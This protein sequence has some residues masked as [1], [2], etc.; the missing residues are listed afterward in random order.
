[1]LAWSQ[2]FILAVVVPAWLW[3]IPFSNVSFVLM[4]LS[5]FTCWHEILP[6]PG[7]PSALHGPANVSQ[8]TAEQSP[9]RDMGKGFPLATEH[10][11]GAGRPVCF[12]TQMSKVR[13]GLISNKTRLAAVIHS[14]VS[15]R[16]SLFGNTCIEEA[17]VI[18]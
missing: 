1:M 13:L 8:C 5:T 6:C 18:Y 14:S 4:F 16:D 7:H 3:S 9:W 10:W 17:E 11:Q 15:N 12:V 2:I